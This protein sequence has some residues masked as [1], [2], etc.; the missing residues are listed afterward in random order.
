M[1]EN[2]LTLRLHDFLVGGE[3]WGSKAG[4]VARG[5]LQQRL[6]S[7][8]STELIRLSM[9]GVRKIDVSFAS[10]AIF[11]FIR[12][13]QG[14][15]TI[16]LVDVADTDVRANLV[17]AAQRTGVPVTLWNGGAAEVAG[18]PVGPAMRKALSLALERPQLRT[19]DLVRVQGLKATAASNLLRQLASRGYLLRRLSLAASGGNEFVYTRIG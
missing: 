16:C 6:A 18:P 1:N 19:A 10:E 17:A 7:Q 2:S 12:E 5:K 14:Q 11:E 8:A 4:I 15:R 13:H 3:G 9:T